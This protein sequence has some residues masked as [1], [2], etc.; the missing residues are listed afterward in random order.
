MPQALRRLFKGREKSTA[1]LTSISSGFSGFDSDAD[2]GNLASY[3]NSLYLYIGVSMISKR[4]AGIE[5]ELYKIK[6]RKG[7][8]AEVIDHPLLALLSEPNKYQTKREFLELTYI[9]YLLSGDC[10]WYTER[11][12]SKNI[13]AMYTLRPD[14]VQIVMSP[15]NTEIVG[16]EYQMGR[17]MRFSPDDIVHIKNVDPLNPLRGSGAVRPATS[18]ILTEAEATKYQANFFQNQGRPDMVA[19]AD[20]PVDDEQGAEF[21]AKW[22]SIFGR[23]K[24]GQ[25][26]LFGNAIKSLQEMNKTPKEM[27]FIATQKFLRG[28]I[29]AALHIPEEMVSSDGSNRATSKEAYKMYLQEAVIPV[30]EAVVDA[31]NSRLVPRVD[32]AVFFAFDDPVPADRDQQLKELQAGVGKWMTQNEARV[33]VG[34]PPIDGADQLGSVS[35]NNQA[36]QQTDQAMQDQAK[37]Y[38]AGR[39]V[40]MK[41]LKAIDELVNLSLLTTPKRQMNSIFATKDLKIAYA[42][43]VNDKVDRKAGAIKDALDGFHKDMLARIL[44]NELT[45]TTFMDVIGEKTAAKALFAPLLV[46][47]YKEFGQ[48]ALDA[49][50]KKASSDQFFT[51]EAMIAAIEARA[52]FFTGSIVDTT[53][54]I[55]KHKIADGIANGD[56][57]EK[58]GQSLREYF[59]D[60]SVGR[61]NT[62]ARTETGFALSKATN[63][64]YQQSAVITGK[65]WINAGDDNVREEHVDNGGQIVGKDEAFSNGEHYPGEHS[66]NCRCVLAPSV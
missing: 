28:D 52:A 35:F 44:K 65:E 13:I 33:I 38:L 39:P 25:V 58:I 2:A 40:M 59:T 4:A 66:V 31:L 46:K 64:A 24:G 61:S 15:D 36:N 7:D 55:L 57:V 41:R 16:Y 51:N 37:R 43:A 11:D 32:E 14:Q 1:L 56:G 42:K 48:D 12:G 21:R 22:K 20:V 45:T 30:V 54:E 23:G 19:F 3:K 60:M 10:F 47:L 53:F 27:D 34:L 8:V 5:L 6:N 17:L 18:R 26:A 50:F 63:D 49:V 9:Y 62:I 29:L